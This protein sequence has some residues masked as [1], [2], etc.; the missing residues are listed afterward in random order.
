MKTELQNF[1][2]FEGNP[3]KLVE[4]PFPDACFDN[5]GTRLPATYANFTIINQAVLV[6]VY[7]LPQD[8]EAIGILKKC[9]PEKEIIA[10]NCRVLVEQHG[11]LHCV[12]MQYPESVKL[13]KEILV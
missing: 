3:Y 4:L 9:F 7:G 5:E 6:P 11:S 8:D 2:D 1:T 10:L 12:T 13:N